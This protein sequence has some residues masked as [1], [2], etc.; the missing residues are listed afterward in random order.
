MNSHLTIQLLDEPERVGFSDAAFARV[1]HHREKGE[2]RTIK[3]FRAYINRPTASFQE[4]SNNS[5][6]HR[7]LEVV[8]KAYQGGGFK[9][10][11]PAIFVALA[12]AA[13]LEV[14]KAS[15]RDAK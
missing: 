2:D 13:Y 8:W 3:R 14:K 9:S 10:N 1:Y 15:V 5:I 6:V 4:G 11:D 7:R 12:E